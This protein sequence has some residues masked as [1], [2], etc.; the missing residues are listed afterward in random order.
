[1]A[2]ACD[3]F[4][5]GLEL[6]RH[7]TASEISSEACRAHDVHTQNFIGLG[8]GQS[9]SQTRWCRPVRVRGHWPGTGT[10]PALYRHALGLQ[11]LLGA[12]HPGNFGAGVDHPGNGV[13]VDVSVSGL[14]SRSATATPSSS[15]LCASI[16]PRT[17]SPTA[18]TPALAGWSCSR[19]RPQSQPRSSSASP[20]ASTFRSDGVGHAANGDDELVHIQHL[21]FALGVGVG[22]RYALLARS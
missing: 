9:T 20:T 7:G 8:I 18:H 2:D 11:L 19:R 16:G 4:G 10:E 22:H 15:A 21:G 1:M 13:E 6:H 5:T 3:V 17:T 14:R 12:A